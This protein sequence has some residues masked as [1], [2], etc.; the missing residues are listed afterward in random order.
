[1]S[2]TSHSFTTGSLSWTI[3]SYALA[4][5]D[6]RSSTAKFAVGLILTLTA[7]LI[8]RFG[9]ASAVT[10]GELRRASL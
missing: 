3:R 5:P 1:M 7:V 8:V 10:A 2:S 9:T 4:R 6:H